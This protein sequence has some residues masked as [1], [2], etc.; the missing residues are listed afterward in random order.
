M[1]TTILVVEDEKIIAKGIEKRLRGLG[2]A[3][4]WSASTGE[5]AIKKASELRPDLVLMDIHLGSGM[6]GVEAAGVIRRQ[7]NLPVVYLTAHSDDAT[8]QRAKLTEPFGYCLKPYEDKELQLAIEIGLY[9]HQMESRLR[10]NEQWLAAT[11]GSIG[12]GVIATNEAG[13]VRFMNWLAEQLTGWTQAEALG[14]EVVEVFQIVEEKT[15]EPVQNPA[16]EALAKGVS[17]TLAENTLL[18]TKAG[19][20]YPIDDSAAP[21]RDVNG[22]VTGAVL[23]FRDI[24]ER[25]RLEE[26]LREAQKLEAIGRLA[27]GIAHDFN[28]IMTV[29]TGYS[30]LLLDTPQPTEVSQEFLRQINMAG[31][32]ATTLTQQILA[33][34]RKQ[35][36]VPCVMSL[37]TIIR[38]MGGMVRRL[39]GEH[40]EFVTDTAH[41]LGSIKAD[42]TQMGQVILNLALNARDAMPHGGKLVITTANT[43]VDE[44]SP[45]RHPD[46]KPGKYAVLSVTDTG[47]GMSEEVLAHLFEPFFSTKEVGKGNGL[48]LASVYGTV[49]QSKGHIEVASQVGV[50]TTFRVY[51]PLVE[52]PKPEAASPERRRAFQGHE[53]ILL[54]EDEEAVRRMTKMVLQRCGYKVL[55]A[56]NGQDALTL[57]ASCDEP[58]HL[59]ITD[60]MMPQ[61]TG[62]MVAERLSLTRP[63][64]RVLF[65]SG[66]TEDLLEHQGVDSAT[67]HF[68][69]KPFNLDALTRK[70]REVL[71]RR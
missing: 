12:D 68:M 18:I 21:I 65:M 8:L 50:G 36:L 48:G 11:L 46:L 37:N 59:L 45:R 3:A 29:I 14:K 32:R 1:T 35:M 40:I 17:V 52:K 61:L 71:E 19:T 13:R 39:V 23:V 22:K 30:D 4:S 56:A 2:Y 20:E 42:P 57:S 69:H 62:R 53:T 55:E 7:L 70:M 24:T 63:A 9:K 28:N 6:D 5:E 43:E 34:S 54:V 47:S 64:M 38:D 51:L 60:L 25:R 67:A 33:F 27:G 26:H 31:K 16:L 58:I 15:H 66:Y 44:L 10:E 41:E 49:K